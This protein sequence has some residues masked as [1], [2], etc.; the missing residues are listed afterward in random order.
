MRLAIS[1]HL[2]NLGRRG[3]PLE[4]LQPTTNS[5]PKSVLPTQESK[6]AHNRTTWKTRTWSIREDHV[7][8]KSSPELML[9]L[10]LE[11]LCSRPH[12]QLMCP[13]TRLLV[14]QPQV[15]LT[16]GIGAHLLA[17]LL[18]LAIL[19]LDRPI[20]NRMHNMHALLAQLPRERLRQ[21]SYRRATS[22]VRRELRTAA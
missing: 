15:R 6:T 5:N 3:M 9:T 2:Q 13:Q 7:M 21:L 14:V 10:H 8:I 16:H 11:L 1:A 17:N 19:V 4:L 18:V 22:A 12:I 20:G